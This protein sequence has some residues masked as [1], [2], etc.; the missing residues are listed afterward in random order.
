MKV[1]MRRHA[2][3]KNVEMVDGDIQRNPP[4]PTT[5]RSRHSPPPVVVVLEAS[6]PAPRENRKARS[7]GGVFYDRLDWLLGRARCSR[8]DMISSIRDDSSFITGG[9]EK[10]W[11]YCAMS[12]WS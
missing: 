1:I 2:R 6:E 9:V 8:A 7:S 10:P 12:N 3:Y 4:P 11:G 5:Y